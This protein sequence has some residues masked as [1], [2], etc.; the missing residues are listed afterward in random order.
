MTKE[1][2][3]FLRNML[4]DRR[5]NILERVK[6][7]AAAW[8]EL[9]EPAIELEE[10]AQKASIAKPYDKLDQNGKIEIEQ[11]DLAL[12]KMTLGDYGV[13]ESCGDDIAEGRLQVLPWARL[14]VE[15]ARE[16]EKQNRSLP[17]TSDVVVTGKIP[18]EF[19]GLT[20]QQIVS[21]IY[22]R[23]QTDE[24]V[25]TEELRISFRKGVVFLDGA[26][27][28]ETE[29]DLILQILSDSLGFSSV[30]DRIGINELS[31]DSDGISEGVSEEDD[32]D[33]QM[34]YDRDIHEEAF[35]A[36]G[37]VPLENINNDMLI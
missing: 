31:I 18:D 7:L 23:L 15:C 22:E 34:F 14:C 30:V 16:Y 5:N 28:S 32:L 25:D 20:N 35:E 19:Q 37:A 2:I 12:I 1:E 27:E 4:L 36:K 33:R 11:I 26:V 21:L 24:R 9:E 10:E 6:R 13:C 17:Q 3:I 8:Q 29:H